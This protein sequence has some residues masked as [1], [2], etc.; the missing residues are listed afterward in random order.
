VEPTGGGPIAAVGVQLGSRWCAEGSVYLDRL[1]WDG[2]PDVVFTRPDHAGQMWRRAWVQAVDEFRTDF[3]EAIRL[4]QDRGAGLLI[5]GTREWADYEVQAVL[6]PFLATAFGL[7]ARVQ[8]LRRYYALVVTAA[9]QLRLIRA[10]DGK[11]V[12]AEAPCPI[13]WG[14]AYHLALRATGPRLQAFLDGREVFD[15][16]DP[17]NPLTTGAMALVCAEGCVSTNAVAVRP[18]AGPA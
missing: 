13:T 4:A 7:A 14:R 15:L 17:A 8:G 9:G 18:V 6:T 10:W 16:V 2:P 1:G 11:T 3:P 5:Q 12:L